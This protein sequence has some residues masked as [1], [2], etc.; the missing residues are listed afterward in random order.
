MCD[1]NLPQVSNLYVEAVLFLEN[2][3]AAPT[4]P[5]R[6]PESLINAHQKALTEY[7]Q[8]GAGFWQFYFALG[9]SA[10]V[11]STAECEEG[12]RDF[13]RKENSAV[14]DTEVRK[15]FKLGNAKTFFAEHLVAYLRHS[16]H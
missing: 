11:G 5:V 9:A 7:V 1:V 12:D 10:L 8:A 15:L 2:L 4:A 13:P 3:A 14:I 6:I 16:D